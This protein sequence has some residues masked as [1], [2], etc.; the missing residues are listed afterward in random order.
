M[1][2]FTIW[3]GY[4]VELIA[5]ALTLGALLLWIEPVAVVAFLRNA[6]IDIATLFS[7]AVFAAA[8]GFLW[9]LYAKD[10][11]KFYR[12]LAKNGAFSAYLNGTIYV[13][14][15][16]FFTTGCLLVCKHVNN[17]PIGLVAFY[18]LLL[19]SINMYSL[20][21]N[22]ASLMRLNAEFNRINDKS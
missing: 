14:G 16:A 21:G 10:D 8:V 9:S 1:A 2:R 18:M 20:I 7:A 17:V 22:V 11:S 12:W 6:A 15:I 19:T 13:I 3:W 4:A 5:A